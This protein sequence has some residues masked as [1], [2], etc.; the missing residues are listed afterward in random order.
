MRVFHR[1]LFGSKGLS[2][3]RKGLALWLGSVALL[4]PCVLRSQDLLFIEADAGLYIQEGAG[5]YVQGG[6][7]NSGLLAGDAV[8]EVDGELWVG[9]GRAAL[10][11]LSDWTADYAAGQ[12]VVGGRGC[13]RLAS[14]EQQIRGSVSQEFGCLVLGA[15][16]KRY[17]L[18]VDLRIR[19]SLDLGLGNQ[20]Q[21]NG[22]QLSLLQPSSDVIRWQQGGWLESESTPGPGMDYGT[23]SWVL[24]GSEPGWFRIPFG[25]DGPDAAL[26]FYADGVHA[27][28]LRAASYGT[29]MNNLPLPA[30]GRGMPFGVTD[31]Y[32][33]EAGGD[34]APWTLD[35]FWILD[36]GASPLWMKLAYPESE[37]SAN[38]IGAEPTL[39]AQF[40]SGSSGWQSN[41]MGISLWP[42]ERAI[43]AWVEQAGAWA[44]ALSSSPLPVSCVGFEARWHHDA[45]LLSWQT[46]TELNNRGFFVQRR[47]AHSDW[48]EIS[49]VEG[50]GTSSQQNNY[51]FNDYTLLLPGTHYYRLMQQD[52]GVVPAQQVCDIAYI[53]LE[54]KR[55]S[56]FS[57]VPNPL[58]ERAFLRLDGAHAGRVYLELF[59]WNGRRVWQQSLNHEG[60]A[61]QDST[62][63]SEYTLHFPEG[64]SAGIY[65]L[66][67]MG[68]ADGHIKIVLL[69]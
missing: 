11:G 38:V 7:R 15:E 2:K 21:L 16:D 46:E 13:V 62:N 51:T 48:Q 34:N 50:S 5:L 56:R 39:Q 55:E 69:P 4:S 10:P 64:L 54:D 63:F 59:D 9:A 29:G 44:M 32:S 8:L 27:D 61:V 24:A 41:D 67:L 52:E 17:G 68:A 19:D 3:L 40:W 14:G 66:R 33:A 60:L 47:D 26:E 23:V 30:A 65:L 1:F 57:L 58:K 6:V 28:T 53:T 37:V 36:P 49:F 18:D 12:F 42:T 25:R 45:V 35:R 22:H 31:L 20:L 43:T